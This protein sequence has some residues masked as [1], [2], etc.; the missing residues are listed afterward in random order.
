M[1]ITFLSILIFTTSQ[2]F[3]QDGGTL[4]RVIDQ[5]LAR[6]ENRVDSAKVTGFVIGCL[7]GDSTWIFPFGRL[8]K[9]TKDAPN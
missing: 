5:L 9:T 3:A 2:L 8:S 6:R 7:D 1:K 4:K